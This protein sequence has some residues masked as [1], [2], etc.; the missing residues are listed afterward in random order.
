MNKK[1]IRTLAVLTCIALL[2]GVALAFLSYEKAPE[3]LPKLS[4][5]EPSQIT[6]VSFTN[7]YGSQDY[8]KNGGV[9]QL[10]GDPDFPVDGILLQNMLTALCQAVPQDIMAGKNT[11]EWGLTAPQCVIELTADSGS[12]VFTVGSMNAVTGQLYVQTDD[13]VYLTDTTILQA[14]GGSVLDLARQTTI[15]TPQDQESVVIMNDTG[16]LT[17][18][19]VGSQTGGADGTWYVL[20]GDT[21]ALADQDMAY[22]YYFLTWD[23]HWLSTAGYVTD[24]SQLAAYG[25]DTPQVRYT[26]TYGGNTFRLLLGDDLPDGTTYAMV[27]G[28]DLVYTIDSVL[29]RWLTQATAESVLTQP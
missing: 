13:A 2:L 29:V 24:A 19:C 15:P 26:L 10:A 11:E 6:G 21:Y 3:V 9:W 18:S 7:L 20:Q 16:T 4:R 27:A 5:F 28:E 14:F 22:N 17:L 12:Q 1:Q 8:V 23:M 25:L